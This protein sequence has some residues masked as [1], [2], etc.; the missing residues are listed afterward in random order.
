MNYGTGTV[1]SLLATM[2]FVGDYDFHLQPSSPC[3]GR[4]TTNF[5]I[6]NAV[7]K[8]DLNYGA[9]EISVPGTDIGCYQSNGRGLQH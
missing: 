5:T 4:G 7:T 3:N 8:V 2:A 1:S 6:S 9:S